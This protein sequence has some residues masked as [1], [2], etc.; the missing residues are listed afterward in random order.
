VIGPHGPATPGDTA[1]RDRIFVCNPSKSLP[2]EDCAKQ[3]VVNIMRRAY[4][5]PVADADLAGPLVFYRAARAQEGFEAG[6]EM[7]LRAI[8]V[9]PEF[10]FRVE[11]DPDGLAP[12][13]PYAISDIQLA[14]RLAS[15]LWSSIP[16]DELL[17]AA[18][19]G[20]LHKPEVLEAQVRRMLTDARS[21]SLVTNFAAQ[22]LYLR[23]LDATTPDMRLFPDFDDNLRQSLRRETE[24]FFE[25]IVRED[26][27][28]LDLIRADYTYLDE[29]LA[30][31]YGI[32]HIYGSRFRR[33]EL[34]PGSHR[35]GLLR[36]GSI[37]TV[38]SYA[39]RTSP[40]IRGKWVL[41]NFLGIPPPPPLPD[42]PA[43][44]T[45]V[46]QDLPVRERLAQHRADP[47][48]AGCHQLMDPIG[49]SLE[50]Y[51]AV[52][53]FRTMEAGNAVDDSGGF[54]D[55]REFD[56]VDGL[57]KA[58]L[59]RPEIFVGVLTEKL[60]TYALG[61]GVEPYDAPAVRA[62]LRDARAQDYRFS[63]LIAGIAKSAPFTM[64]TSQ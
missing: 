1:S 33:V 24:L 7:A 50:S 26:R 39:T 42:V 5:R 63:S 32:P 15:F 51:D 27:S 37:L 2:E 20:D 22:W 16:D 49:L 64:R 19:R 6:V 60:L 61:R 3:I 54:F 21:E 47:D 25:S 12:K 35:G 62:I 9:S 58:L 46:N 40:V 43:L 18:E 38:T 34:G 53:R 8:L 14:S 13:T 17:A 23:N 57:E 45:K 11:R 36:H 56:G 10:L 44:D 48:C 59:E 29:R 41:D 52:G 30:K 4:R 55:G 28:A 31:H